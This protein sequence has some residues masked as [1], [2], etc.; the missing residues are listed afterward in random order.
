MTKKRRRPVFKKWDKCHA[1][2]RSFC[3]MPIFKTQKDNILFLE[4]VVK[5][6]KKFKITIR[7]IAIMDDHYHFILEQTQ[8]TGIKEFITMV[9]LSYAKYYNKKTKRKG[10][11]FEC[12]YH[13]KLIEDWNYEINIYNYVLNNPVKRK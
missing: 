7:A 6:A 2:N 9:K 12:R 1:Y 13:A 5:Y 3:K 11:V 10:P 8:E 4:Y